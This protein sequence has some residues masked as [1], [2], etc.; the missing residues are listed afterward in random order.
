MEEQTAIVPHSCARKCF[1]EGSMF[2]GLR[3]VGVGFCEP[4]A[5]LNQRP[6]PQKACI[7]PDSVSYSNWR[8]RHPSERLAMRLGGIA[9]FSHR[10]MVRLESDTSQVVC[11][12]D[13]DSAWSRVGHYD[14]PQHVEI[15][16]IPRCAMDLSY[17]SRVMRD[18]QD[19]IDTQCI[20]AKFNV[21]V[22]PHH[23][24]HFVSSFMGDYDDSVR[25][26]MKYGVKST[27]GAGTYFKEWI[28]NPHWLLTGDDRPI[29]QRWELYNQYRRECYPEG[30]EPPPRTPSSESDG[31]FDGWVERAFGDQALPRESGPASDVRYGDSDQQ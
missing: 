25:I 29:F 4:T 19:A 22:F 6:G 31:F 12:R 2:L 13:L 3:L 27:A 15:W 21:T 26:L 9:H 10:H 28:V 1:C 18:M 24:D 11:H 16:R 23:P 5:D 17:A 30:F 8:N 20:A 14:V 7:Q